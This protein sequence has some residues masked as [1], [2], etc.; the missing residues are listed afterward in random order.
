MATAGL[1]AYF[2]YEVIDAVRESQDS[3]R[4]AGAGICA[5]FIGAIVTTL[6]ADGRKAGRRRQSASRLDDPQRG[7]AA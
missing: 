4:T 7:D 5:F 3:G 6:I 2:L 1:L